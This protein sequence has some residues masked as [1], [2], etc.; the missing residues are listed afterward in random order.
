MVTPYGVSRSTTSSLRPP[1][2]GFGKRPAPKFRLFRKILY[3]LPSLRATTLIQAL[4]ALI[5]DRISTIVGIVVAHLMDTTSNDSS[6][7]LANM[8]L[9]TISLTVSDAEGVGYLI[10]QRGW[11][12]AAED[13]VER[14]RFRRRDLRPTLR[15]CYDMLGFWDRFAHRVDTSLGV[16]EMAGS[17]IIGCRTLP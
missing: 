4:D 8:V 15:T 5:P 6:R 14:Y 13:I 3:S 7:L 11:R 1:M 9:R 10:L 17:R 2:G 12:R 16:G